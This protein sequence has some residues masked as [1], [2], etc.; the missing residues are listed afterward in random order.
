MDN[1]P[2]SAMIIWRS[3]LG[4]IGQVVSIYELASIHNKYR[5]QYRKWRFTGT[6]HECVVLTED[7][8][9]TRKEALEYASMVVSGSFMTASFDLDRCEVTWKRIFPTTPAH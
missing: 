8:T 3:T 5:K 7:D 2:Q 4:V 9:V 1:R 6:T